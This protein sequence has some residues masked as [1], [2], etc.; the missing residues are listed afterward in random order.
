[1]F[2]LCRIIP[3]LLHDTNLLPWVS[4][5][6][7]WFFHKVSSSKISS[8]EDRWSPVADQFTTKWTTVFCRY[9]VWS[10]VAA[11]S[12]M[13][14]IKSCAEV[15]KLQSHEVCWSRNKMK[16][17]FCKY[18]FFIKTWVQHSM[19][20][21]QPLFSTMDSDMGWFQVRLMALVNF[22]ITADE[23]T[24]FGNRESEED[25]GLYTAFIILVTF[26]KWKIIFD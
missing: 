26:G 10:T 22:N 3:V 23:G 19:T 24:L 6:W 9:F 5:R 11:V 20:L 8:D 17:L 4:L 12:V 18:F 1:M 13:Q 15:R 25:K 2:P 14:H 21:W 16:Y 7:Q